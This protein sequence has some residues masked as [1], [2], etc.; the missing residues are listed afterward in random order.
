MQE[1]TLARRYANA[2][3]QLAA[4]Q[5]I[6]DQTNQELQQFTH[7]VQTTPTMRNLLTN[8]TANTNHQHDV[9]ENYINKSMPHATVANFLRLLL[10]KRRMAFIDGIAAAFQRTVDERSGSTTLEVRTAHPLNEQQQKRLQDILSKQTGKEI[11]LSIKEDSG[12]LGG[13][14]VQIGSVMMD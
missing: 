11:S 7:V 2:L 8:P 10:H 1:S 5:G 14:V 6:L 12:L 4:E 9:V 13:M 3:A